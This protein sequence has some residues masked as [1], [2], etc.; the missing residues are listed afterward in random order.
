MRGSADH[1]DIP[2]FASYAVLARRLDH[3]MDSLE[4]CDVEEEGV[5]REGALL[6]ENSDAWRRLLMAKVV[7]DV[8]SRKTYP[9]VDSQDRRHALIDLPAS[10]WRNLRSELERLR[11]GVLQGARMG[12]GR[13][14]VVDDRPY[15]CLNCQVEALEALAELRDRL[16][17]AAAAVIVDNDR[18]G[19]LVR[20]F[21][22]EYIDTSAALDGRLQMIG[23]IH[24]VDLF[25]PHRTLEVFAGDGTGDPVASL[26]DGIDNMIVMRVFPL[27]N[28]QVEVLRLL[29]H[30]EAAY[31]ARPALF[32]TGYFVEGCRNSIAS[33][34]GSKQK[35][36]LRNIQGPRRPPV[37]A[38]DSE[39]SSS[40]VDSP[41]AKKKR[42]KSVPYSNEEK[43]ML[44][45]GVER[46]GVGKWAEIL[47]H[48][49]FNNRTSGNLKDLFRTLTKTKRTNS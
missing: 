47:V 35:Q 34:R 48:Y 28:V 42:K 7:I 39:G 46:F 1:D 12:G 25:L 37:L 22:K 17:D 3:Y 11:N 32:T 14:I 27:Q 13:D 38:S 24:Y 43:R 30:W 40:K 36:P 41:A 4:R 33:A 26:L 16:R 49:D 2:N 18:E 6:D 8:C 23:M 19:A 29:R 20:R 45:E 9:G 31:L 15:E 21:A 10:W 5:G 44:L